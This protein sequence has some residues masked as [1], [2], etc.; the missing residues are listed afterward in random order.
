MRTFNS[1]PAKEPGILSDN[2]T[3]H[4]LTVFLFGY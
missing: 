2:I 4:H 3:V 1:E